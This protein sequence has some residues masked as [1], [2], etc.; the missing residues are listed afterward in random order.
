MIAAMGFC[1][2]IGVGHTLIS[3]LAREAR[4]RR[5]RNTRRRKQAWP[6]CV[7]IWLTVHGWR[8]TA[9][10]WRKR[11]WMWVIGSLSPNVSV[12]HVRDRAL[13]RIRTQLHSLLYWAKVIL[14][15]ARYE[16]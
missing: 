13:R 10:F 4:F 14:W 7:A 9:L 15:P 3:T 6:N 16:A 2:P 12:G 1:R 11:K 5:S 8:A